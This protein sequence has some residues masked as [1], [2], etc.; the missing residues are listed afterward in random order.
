MRKEK[1]SPLIPTSSMADIAFLLLIFFLVTTTIANDQGL[2]LLLPPDKDQIDLVELNDRNVMK[3]LINSADLVQI[4]GERITDLDKVDEMVADFILN[5]DKDPG[6]SDSPQ[7]AVV[8]L[9]TD[10]NTTHRQFIRVLDEIHEAYNTIYANRAG[11][12]RRDWLRVV[13][14]L[15]D[16]ENREIY[17]QAR[18][19]QPDGSLLI[20]MQISIAEP[21]SVPVTL[22]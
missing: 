8:S 16:P 15:S 22:R 21:V 9:R 20:P 3:I 18:G 10:R 6:L 14:N 19:R 11:L 17:E 13:K 1:N 7:K 4:E 2:P 12:S 5:P